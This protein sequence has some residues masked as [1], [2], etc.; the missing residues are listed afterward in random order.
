M[1]KYNPVKVI[2]EDFI[3]PEDTVLTY[4]N[5]V[6]RYTFFEKDV[7]IGDSYEYEDTSSASFSVEFVEEN[8]GTIFVSF[9]DP[10]EEVPGPSN[11]KQDIPV[12]NPPDN[13]KESITLQSLMDTWNDAFDEVWDRIL[14]FENKFD[15]IFKQLR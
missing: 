9:E 1:K 12:S 13:P 6:G 3:L 10:T 15:R 2:T 4:N 11:E 5:R 8:L 7:E 14:I